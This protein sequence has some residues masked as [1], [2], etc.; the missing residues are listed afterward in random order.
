[1]NPKF[2]V[3][4]LMLPGDPGGG[5]DLPYQRIDQVYLM[6]LFYLVESGKNS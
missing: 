3:D 1:M 4:D 2:E 5:V 6:F